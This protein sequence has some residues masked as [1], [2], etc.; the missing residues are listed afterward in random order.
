[1]TT[2][3]IVTETFCLANLLAIYAVMWWPRKERR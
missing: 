3:E 1:M 2:Y